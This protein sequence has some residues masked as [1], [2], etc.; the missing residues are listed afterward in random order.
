MVNQSQVN[1][2]EHGRD[3]FLFRMVHNKRLL[4]KMSLMSPICPWI[5]LVSRKHSATKQLS[6]VMVNTLRSKRTIGNK[7]LTYM[8]KQI[9][10]MS[11][12]YVL[13][14]LPIWM[15]TATE[16]PL[17]LFHTCML[18]TYLVT[19]AKPQLEPLQNIWVSLSVVELRIHVLTAALVRPVRRISWTSAKNFWSP[20]IFFHQISVQVVV[21]PTEARSTGF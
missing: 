11:P 6:V 19:W 18:T 5:Y 7:S 15:K 2:S 17:P 21:Q 1:K 12:E 8:S 3:M 4:Y 9:M 10:V 16:F 13:R 14:R 20:V